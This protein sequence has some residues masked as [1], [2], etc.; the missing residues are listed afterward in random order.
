MKRDC[1]QSDDHVP[2][3]AGRMATHDMDDLAAA[4]L[5]NPAIENRSSL[6]SRRA[7]QKPKLK[8]AFFAG[9]CR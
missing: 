8:P 9:A 1:S 6:D 4:H 7:L 3:L 2:D 5:A